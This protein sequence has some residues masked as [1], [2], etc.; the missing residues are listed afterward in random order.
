MHF[1]Q[2]SPWQCVMWV[3][4]TLAVSNR[5]TA[6]DST[7]KGCSHQR[8]SFL[9][10]G[11]PQTCTLGSKYTSRTTQNHECAR[12]LSDHSSPRTRVWL[13]ME[14]RGKSCEKQRSRDCEK[15][16]PVLL[17][18]VKKTAGEGMRRLWPQPQIS[19]FS[20]GDADVSS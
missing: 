18:S 13:V 19:H 17:S 9:R 5:D 11:A 15:P 8:S 3:T 2:Y 4:A 20:S 1:T 16:G 6:Q 7:V 14:A 12:H 10:E